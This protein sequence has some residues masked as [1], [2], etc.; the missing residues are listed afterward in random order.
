MAELIAESIEPP[1]LWEPFTRGRKAYRE[2]N[3][4]W[5]WEGVCPQIQY[6]EHH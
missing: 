4:K 1:F 2:F 5:G 6:N 3:L